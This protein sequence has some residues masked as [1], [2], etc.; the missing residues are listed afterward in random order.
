[1]LYCHVCGLHAVHPLTQG[2]RLL[3][4]T[5]DC[6][7]LEGYQDIGVCGSCRTIV[8][9]MSDSWRSLCAGIYAEYS[10]YR[11]ASGAE[12]FVFTSTG[13]AKGR[14]SRILGLLAEDLGTR[15][16][17]W[18]DFGCGNGTFIRALSGQF[19]RMELVGMEFDEHNRDAIMG[20]EGVRGFCTDWGDPL[21]EKLDVVSL[22]HVLEHIENPRELL[23][24]IRSR[25][26]ASGQLIIQ[27]PHVWSN[28]YVL[29]I[30]DHATHF[31]PGTL[32]QLVASSGFDIDWLAIDA[33][34]GELTLL[35]SRSSQK[36]NVVS[37]GHQRSSTDE[38][39]R[40]DQSAV[41]AAHG[42]VDSLTAVVP[43]LRMQHS[44]NVPIAILGTS[45]AGTWAGLALGFE[46]KYWVD[47]N[48]T[49]WGS[50]WF[51]RTVVSVSQLPEGAVV[52]A[53]L[54][55]PKANAAVRRLTELRSDIK[56]LAPPS[57]SDWKA[58][59]TEQGRW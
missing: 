5:S 23:E 53:V 33:V 35:A 3:R 28:P 55:P 1:M 24:K 7:P 56:F 49:R 32:S 42:L 25:L 27:V 39:E 17:R 11:Q 38:A 45:I 36:L 14:S 37:A 9:L 12:D 10:A 52:L 2:M 13:L 54:A 51:D 34:P 40:S 21:T 48:E 46:H 16:G 20:I 8:T 57:F 41:I 22:I 47:E 31:G 26:S 4:I 19:P 43:W 30:A 15:S 44:D 29:A 18:L 59:L 6:V 50:T 58:G